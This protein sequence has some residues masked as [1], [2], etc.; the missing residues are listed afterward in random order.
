M[1]SAVDNDVE[2]DDGRQSK[3]RRPFLDSLLIAQQESGMLSDE[4]IQEETDTFMFEVGPG[5][6]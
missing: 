5:G 6:F 3:Q 2:S 4:N 1:E